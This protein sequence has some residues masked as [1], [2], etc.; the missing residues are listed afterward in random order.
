MVF[1]RSEFNAS[2]EFMSNENNRGPVF[3][4]NLEQKRLHHTA[5]LRVTKVAISQSDI[6]YSKASQFQERLL[7]W[8]PSGSH[9]K[10]FNRR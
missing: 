7:S 3:F 10:K 8:S 2:L 9:Q 4:P 5:R 6:T 1:R